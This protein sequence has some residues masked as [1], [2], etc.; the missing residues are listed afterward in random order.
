M[1]KFRTVQLWI[2]TTKKKDM[3]SYWTS[4]KKINSEINHKKKIQ[5]VKDCETLW[6]SKEM[7]S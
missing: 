5:I 4:D 6:Y 3:K 7:I 2:I 1:S